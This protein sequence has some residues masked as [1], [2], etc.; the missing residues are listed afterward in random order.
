MTSMTHARYLISEGWGHI[1]SD[2][3]E[4]I[5]RWAYDRVEERLIALEIQR[6]AG[7]APASAEAY[8]DV[9]ESVRQ[10]LDLNGIDTDM[11]SY[12]D[13]AALPNW[14]FASQVPKWR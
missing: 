7:F 14:A 10:N 2:G 6:T 1:F 4:R 13:I 8:A 3:V 12:F 11:A 5:T 9:Q